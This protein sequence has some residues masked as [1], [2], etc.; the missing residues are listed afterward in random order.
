MTPSRP[1]IAVQK[2]DIHVIYHLWESSSWE[3]NYINSSDGGNTWNP[4]KRISTDDGWNS[5]YAKIAV[6]GS[7]IHV[8]W[9]DYRHRDESFPFN[10]ELYY[11]RS[12]D[13]GITWDDGLGNVGQDRRLTNAF[14]ESTEASISVE[15]DTVHVVWGDTRNGVTTG[16]IYYMRSLDKGATWDDGLGNVGQDRRLTTNATN[17]GPST[18]AVNGSTIHVAWVDEVWP[19]PNY[20][21]YYRN[22]TD[23]GFSW[24]PIILL[25]GGVNGP[26]RVDITVYG[27]DVHIVWD[28]AY[29]DKDIYYINSTDAGGYWSIPLRISINDTFNSYW[30]RIVVTNNMRHIAWWD[31][32]DGNSEIYYKRFP[33]FSTDTTPPTL[34]YISPPT[35]PDNATLATNQKA[36]IRVHYY[37]NESA[38]ANA[39]LFWQNSTGAWNSKP[40]TNISFWNG[41]YNNYFETNFT[42]SSPTSVEYY[43]NCTNSANLT[44]MAPVRTMNFANISVNDPYPI[45]GYAYLYNG[46]GGVYNPLPLINAQVDITWYNVWLNDW[47]TITTNTIG[48][49]QYSVDLM[50]YTNG[51]VVF[52]NATAP[53]PFSNRGYNSTVVDVT[54]APGGRRQDVVCGVPYDVVLTTYPLAVPVNTPFGI[55]YEI[56]D[57][58]GNLCQGYFTFSDGP[59]NISADGAYSAP[60]DYTFDG[61]LSGTPGTRTEIVSFGLPLGQRWL[62]VSEGPDLNPYLTPW[63]AFNHW[64]GTAGF[65]KDWDNVTINV[66]GAGFLW[67]LEQGWN[68]IS[69]P[70]SPVQK[71][72]NG[73]FDSFDALN[74]T[75]A[76]TGDSG[77]SIA[78]RIGGIPSAYNI[79]DIGMP[80]NLAFP[81]DGVHGYWLYLSVPGPFVVSVIAQNYSV[82]GAN[83]ANLAVGWNLMGFTHNVSGGGAQPGGWNSALSASHF[84]NGNVDSDLNVPPR[85]K[86]VITWWNP[87]VQWYHS[88]VVTLTFPGMPTHDWAYDTTYAYGYW[89]WADAAV[90][91]T[92][93]T[94]Y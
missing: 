80:E 51:G 52:C 55:T 20:Y 76:I 65:L 75:Y 25:N 53:A 36:V 79:F 67:R 62:N 94:D 84:T 2:M 47:Q 50:N 9:V 33:D 41:S 48:T 31:D 11:K 40:M 28:A 15:G 10:T 58:D 71:G 39:T 44:T 23:N 82:A 66:T 57:I 63:G 26:N 60:P 77:M 64:N 7:E 46:A 43:V 81:M 34:T 83:V 24:N 78:D 1:D 19:G 74:I 54:G 4:S 91:V 3:I 56:Q 6:N 5:Q 21:L 35:P 17:H 42:E 16:D 92:F 45:Y 38:A 70:A 12:L 14:Y 73:I 37:D 90:L 8:V 49:G 59:I 61:L 72:G 89:V 13:G 18:V 85:N 30:P 68:L 93:D 27:N 87:I 86:L 88:Y 69:V 32:R 29:D 22:S